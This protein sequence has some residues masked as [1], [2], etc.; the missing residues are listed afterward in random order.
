MERAIELNLVDELITSDDYLS[1]AAKQANI[2]EIKYER[3][4]PVSEKLIS[5]GANILSTIDGR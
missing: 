5:F 3:K 2:F 1:T 4:K